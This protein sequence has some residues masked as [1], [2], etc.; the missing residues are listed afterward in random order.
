VTWDTTTVAN[1]SY[2]LTSKAIDTSGN[3]TTSSG[4]AVTV[5]NDL[6]LNGG[7]EGSS[8]PWTLTGQAFWMTS[9]STPHGGTGNLEL[10]RAAWQPG[11]AEQSVTLPA[12]SALTLS[13][14]MYI[15]STETTTFI[16]SDRFSVEILNSAG[17][18]IATLANF[19]NLNKGSGYVQYAYSLAS[20]AG[21]TVRLRFSAYQ[22]G[23][24]ITVFRVDD[25]SVK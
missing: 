3:A 25:V 2:T 22:S 9:G 11:A 7:F 21:Q 10:G 14:W 15:T 24:L 20:Y 16:Q 6:I 5:A 17:T 12:G 1:G 8:S 23:S 18:V 4:V 19:S 13:F